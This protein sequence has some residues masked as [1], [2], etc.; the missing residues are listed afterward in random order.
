MIHSCK[1][2]KVKCIDSR[3]KGGHRYRRYKC[4]HCGVRF[5]TVELRVEKSSCGGDTVLD[6]LRQEMR[7][8]GCITGEQEVAIRKL[9][10]AFR[11][12]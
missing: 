9:I 5:S 7:K 6:S 4:L 3:P 11:K 2:I 12:G 10:K 8:D 1:H